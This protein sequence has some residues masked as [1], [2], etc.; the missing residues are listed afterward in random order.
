MREDYYVLDAVIVV[1]EAV[2]DVQVR[3]RVLLQLE[4][5]GRQG[6]EVGDEV[7]G[8]VLLSIGGELSLLLNLLVEVDELKIDAF[9]VYV[10]SALKVSLGL[11]VQFRLILGYDIP[12]LIA[13]LCESLPLSRAPL[14]AHLPTQLDFRVK[15][16]DFNLQEMKMDVN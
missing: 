14:P 13:F 4:E 12:Q 5:F 11:I 9:F 7:A 10:G 6:H 8:T 1:I 2:G 16:R 3:C 15:I